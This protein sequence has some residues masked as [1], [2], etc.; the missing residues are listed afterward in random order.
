MELRTTSLDFSQPLSGSGQ[1]TADAAT[2]TGQFGVRDWSDD[3]NDEYDGN[4]D[5]V[6]VVELQASSA[7]PPRPDLVITGMELHQ[8]VQ[9]FRSATYLCATPPTGGCSFSTATWFSRRA[10]A[11]VAP[12][13]PA[14]S[15][16][17][18]APHSRE[19]RLVRACALK[20]GPNR[21]RPSP[22]T[23][24]ELF[25]TAEGSGL[26]RKTQTLIRY[27]VLIGGATALVLASSA[28]AMAA[29]WTR[30]DLTA[31]TGAPS[32]DGAGPWGYTTDL[33]GQGPVARVV[34]AA[35]SGHV[36]ELSV[37]GG[38][39]WKAA[40]LT[41]RT[42]APIDNGAGPFGYTTDLTGQGPVARV[43]YTTEFGHIWELSVRGGHD[44]KAAD[45]T[46]RTGAPAVASGPWGY[47][48]NLTGQGPVARVV[49]AAASGH[50]WELSVRGGHD[51]AKA[52]LTAR[53]GAPLGTAPVGYT[54][55]LTGQGPVAR[56]VY[57]TGVGIPLTA[58]GEL[59]RVPATP[60]GHIEELS[61][62]GGHD[63]AKADLTARTGAPSDN[64]GGPFGYTTNL[65]GQ[66]PAAR[67]LY[68][69]GEHIWELSVLGGHDWAKAD[70]TA[71]TGA[72]LGQGPVG[73]TTNL[74][75]Q[76]PVARVVYIT[77][78]SHIEE[79]SVM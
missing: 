22:C 16:P 6:V 62:R 50:I 25:L 63:W 72:P 61:V 19:R 27:G 32:V 71:K 36:W 46:A 53:T 51:W 66:G 56:V 35:D 14:A 76:G 37:R 41:A 38:N 43:I 60:I 45:L 24:A 48:T 64:D 9:Y 1:R 55:N 5:R 11:Q 49:Y 57:R 44:W 47:T 54:T 39:D 12:L 42:G 34:Y 26:V 58:S 13:T 77:A 7:Q 74:T 20:A 31:R 17:S 59:A 30:A 8:A 78:N 15:A 73:Y 67:V 65:T 70:L 2:V 69:T 18:T 3:W 33:T 10:R 4:I 79:L 52:D 68:S 21:A 75:G 28:T 23:G 40:D 29:N